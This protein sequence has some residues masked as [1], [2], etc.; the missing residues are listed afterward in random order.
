MQMLIARLTHLICD[1]MCEIL[2]TWNGWI[3]MVFAINHVYCA[4]LCCACKCKFA[5]RHVSLTQ[6]NASV[7]IESMRMIQTDRQTDKITCTSRHE[8]WS[9]R[10]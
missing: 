8:K 10:E 9:M 6:I 4:V 3:I 1:C 7:C 5:Y 2:S